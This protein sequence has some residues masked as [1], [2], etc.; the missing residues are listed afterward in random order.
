MSVILF[1]S[2]LVFTAEAKKNKGGDETTSSNIE[3]TTVSE[4]SS[5]KATVPSDKT[6]EKFA[7]SLLNTTGKNF[8]PNAE[9]LRY[10]TITFAADNS[11]TANAVV[12]VMDEEMECVESG[13]WEM[14]PAKSADVANMS[15]VITATDCPT[16]TAPTNLRMELTLVSTESGFHAAFR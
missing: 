15:W 2:S 7:A 3:S 8:S 14:D 9:G 13:T 16:R 12:A 11:F 10:N 4:K 1:L 6:S 5:A